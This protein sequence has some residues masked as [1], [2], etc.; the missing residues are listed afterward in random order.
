MR[1]FSWYLIFLLLS[2]GCVAQPHQ[3]KGKVVAIA[4][5][6]T[7]TLLHHQEQI[8]IRLHGI[9]CPERGQDF[10]TVA[11]EK[12]S[13]LIF[14]KEVTVTVMDTDRYGRTIGLVQVDTMVVNTELLR[15]GL[16]WH[17]KQYDKQ[18]HWAILELE[19]REAKRGLWAHPNPIAPWE[20]RRKK[21]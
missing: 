10:G 18:A 13:S 20:F 14:G 12:L 19:A 6:D 15:A 7:F 4:D 3:L 16:A 11:R 21:K 8:R 5:G 17:Y 2:I 1:Q 9:D